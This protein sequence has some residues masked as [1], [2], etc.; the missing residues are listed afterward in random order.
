[1]PDTIST[2][3]RDV[4]ADGWGG[5]REGAMF[6]M[7]GYNHGSDQKSLFGGVFTCEKFAPVPP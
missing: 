1:M 4:S 7:V 2:C 3:A 5:F 6:Y